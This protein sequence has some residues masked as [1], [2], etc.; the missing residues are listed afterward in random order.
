MTSLEQLRAQY[1]HLSDDAIA[2]LAAVTLK[3]ANNQVTRGDFLGIVKKAAPDTPI[4][5]VD[6]PKQI[7]ARVNAEREAREKFEQEQRNRWV[8]E[9]LAKQRSS[10]QERFGLSAED[11]TAMEKMM[12]EKGADGRTQLPPDYNWAAQLYKQQTTPATPTNYGTGGYGPLDLNRAAQEKGFEGLM[13]DPDNWSLRTAHS[14]I[15]DAHRKGRAP[16]F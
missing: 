2:D 1:P 10:V 16:A 6:I 9:D 3:V 7:D 13:D 11:M 14:M 5:E 15:D 4:P 8:Q 12:T